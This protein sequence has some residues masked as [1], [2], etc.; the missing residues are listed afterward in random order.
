MSVN[1]VPKG[2][3]PRFIQ[4]MKTGLGYEASG[5]PDKAD[6][7][8]APALRTTGV[9]GLGMIAKCLVGNPG[10]IWYF[11]CLGAPSEEALA[12]FMPTWEQMLASIKPVGN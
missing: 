3:V 4:W 1:D 5:P 6:V 9:F 2:D 12:E 10:K 8:G 7:F 11:L